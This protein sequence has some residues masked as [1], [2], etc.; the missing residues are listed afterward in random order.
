MIGY[1]SLYL[2]Y[3]GG[4]PNEVESEVQRLIMWYEGI[5]MEGRRCLLGSPTAYYGEGMPTARETYRAHTARALNR[6][7]HNQEEVV[8]RVCYHPVA[9]VQKERTSAD[10]LSGWE[11]SSL[12]QEG[13]HACGASCRKCSWGRSTCWRPTGSAADVGGSWC[14]TQTSEER[15]VEQYGR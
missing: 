12:R 11:G 13:E 5:P 9:E 8:R 7:C 4:Q 14:W 3:W 2:P 1:Q 6:M 10:A 15:R